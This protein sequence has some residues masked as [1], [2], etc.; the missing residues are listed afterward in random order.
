MKKDILLTISL[1]IFTLSA[2]AN[3]WE[4]LPV[5]GE[6]YQ[7]DFAIA[8][9]I[10]LVGG[11]TDFDKEVDNDDT[12]TLGIEVSLNCPLLKPPNHI[13]RQQISYVSTDENGV[14]T[15]SLEISPH[16][17][18]AMNDKFQA[19]FGPSIGYT[20]VETNAGDDS[21]FTYGLGASVRYNISQNLFVGGEARYAKSKELNIAGL[22]NDIDNM[23]LLAKVGYQF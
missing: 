1:L 22:D 8:I 9:A 13:I 7:S 5:T 21:A 6:N 3:E 14:E 16:H 18:F 11:R 23:R 10:A 12:S 4:F 19:G 17:M 2:Q 20:K 15:S